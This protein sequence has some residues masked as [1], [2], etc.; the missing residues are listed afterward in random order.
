MLGQAAPA[1]WRSPRRRGA[2]SVPASVR[3]CLLQA[4][5]SSAA[6][7]ARGTATQRRM[8]RQR[9][10]DARSWA[11]LLQHGSRGEVGLSGVDYFDQA[12]LRID[13]MDRRVVRESA[14]PIGNDG[15]AEARL[16]LIESVA[17]DRPRSE[18]A[19]AAASRA[20]QVSRELWRRIVRRVETDADEFDR[21]FGER[22]AKAVLQLRKLAAQR[23]AIR[24]T[25][26]VD[27]IDQQPFAVQAGDVDART[28][29]RF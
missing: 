29:L 27:E 23:H 28:R 20:L 12:T 24:R 10:A 9:A 15:N 13:D 26:R 11:E 6:Q 1:R 4:R 2:G 21:A 22:P 7:G 18:P 8:Q 16:E 3:S 17:A 14:H 19:C 5:A 25:A